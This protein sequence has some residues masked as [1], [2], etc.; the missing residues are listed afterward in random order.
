LL[1][2]GL[3]LW[4][5]NSAVYIADDVYFCLRLGDGE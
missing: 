2:Q 1:S 3:I 5:V 4:L